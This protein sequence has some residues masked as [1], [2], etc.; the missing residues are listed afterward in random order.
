MPILRRK[1]T[2]TQIF[3]PNSTRQP[4]NVFPVPLLRVESLFF[5]FVF[6][7]HLCRGSQGNICSAAGNW[8]RTAET[9]ETCEVIKTPGG[10]RGHQRWS[11]A[12][13]HSSFQSCP[14]CTCA[15]NK[16]LS[17]NVPYVNFLLSLIYSASVI[18]S[19]ASFFCFVS[20]T[21]V[22]TAITAIVCVW[23]RQLIRSDVCLW[24]IA[25]KLWNKLEKINQQQEQKGTVHLKWSGC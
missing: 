15:Q 12:V 8:L 19:L 17:S 10:R 20:L 18:V 7:F 3:C 2:H 9:W 24:L 13:L 23:D 14:L 6:V 11:D 21:A 1:H 25:L 5:G 16:P 22:I 4:A